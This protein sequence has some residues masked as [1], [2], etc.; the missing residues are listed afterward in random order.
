MSVGNGWVA[1]CKN[2][3]YSSWV[4]IGKLEGEEDGEEMDGNGREDGDVL[5]GVEVRNAAR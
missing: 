2:K 4:G 5:E 1:C 3:R